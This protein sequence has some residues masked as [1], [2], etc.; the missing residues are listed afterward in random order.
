MDKF[1]LLPDPFNP[2]CDLNATCWRKYYGY[3]D[4]QDDNTTCWKKAVGYP[5]DCK[6]DDYDCW[7]K[8]FG[9]VNCAD[10]DT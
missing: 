7:L 8:S 9:Y 5:K 6:D 2:M 4:C 1:G 3:P 10:G